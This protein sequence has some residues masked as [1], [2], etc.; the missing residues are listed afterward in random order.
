MLLNSLLTFLTLFPPISWR[1]V[2]SNVNILEWKYLCNLIQDLFQKL[3]DL[4]L[5]LNSVHF[6]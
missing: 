5:S 2:S 6:T 1:F 4:I 3:E